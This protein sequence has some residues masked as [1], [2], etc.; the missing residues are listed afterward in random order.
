MR[1]TIASKASRPTTST[2]GRPSRSPVERPRIAAYAGFTARRRSERSRTTMGSGDVSKSRS[3]ST[4]DAFAA[5]SFPA[6]SS[7]APPSRTISAGPWSGARTTWPRPSAWTWRSRRRSARAMRRVTRAETNTARAAAAIPMPIALAAATRKVDA[8]SAY[9]RLA[10]AAQPTRPTGT[11]AV[12]APSWRVAFATSS[13]RR[14]RATAPVSRTPPAAPPA[15][16][17]RNTTFPC[18]R[19]ARCRRGPAARTRGASSP[20]RVASML[21]KTTPFRSPAVPDRAAN[22]TVGAPLGTPAGGRR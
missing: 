10:M 5:T 19:R 2:S 3:C 21:A 8:A 14:A 9:D 7:N 20:R 16:S 12:M 4:S 22:S 17:R 15:P 1:G 13:P 6:I 18:D 11:A